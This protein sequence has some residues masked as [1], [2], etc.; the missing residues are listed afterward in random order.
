MLLLEIM[1]GVAAGFIGCALPGLS[2]PALLLIS[3]FSMPAGISCFAAQNVY[4]AWRELLSPGTTGEP[5]IMALGGKTLIFGSDRDQ[6]VITVAAIKLTL[7]AIGVIAG[8]FL[9]QMGADGIHQIAPFILLPLGWI[10]LRKTS[11]SEVKASIISLV[12]LLGIII[13]F[14][15]IPALLPVIYMALAA[16]QK[17]HIEQKADARHEI[18][19]L[20][21]QPPTILLYGVIAGLLPGANPSTLVNATG[22][23]GVDKRLLCAAINAM[24]EGVS[25]GIFA[26]GRATGKTPLSEAIS[27]FQGE[28]LPIDVLLPLIFGALVAIALVPIF[29]KT[30]DT[31]LPSDKQYRPLVTVATWGVSV[32]YASVNPFN[33]VFPY[34]GLLVGVGVTIVAQAAGKAATQLPEKTRP[35][36]VSLPIIFL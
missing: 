13:C 36:L 1:F 2:M 24:A 31:V 11:P 22:P 8:Y 26:F 9:T 5:E 33:Y 35:L 12:V 23:V 20:R 15:W 19:K 7:L 6:Q 10:T 32:F 29:A 14:S 34:A 30:L 21:L 18:H 25:L 4:G 28:I 17:I 27:K 3:F 16:N